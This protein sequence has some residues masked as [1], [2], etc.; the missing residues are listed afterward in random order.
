MTLHDAAVA[1]KTRGG[2]TVALLQSRPR[3]RP[4]P[5]V[6]RM[7]AVGCCSSLFLH[8]VADV[9]TFDL[10]G[11]AQ[12]GRR[13]RVVPVRHHR[14]LPRRD[15]GA[16]Q[17]WCDDQS[18]RVR[19]PAA[20]RPGV[21]LGCH[22]VGRFHDPG[23]HDQH[24][25]GARRGRAVQDRHALFELSPRHLP[26]GLLRGPR[27]AQSR[28]RHPVGD[29]AANAADV[30][31]QPGIGTARLRQ[32]GRLRVLD[33]PGR[34]R[35]RHLL[36]Q[37]QSDRHRRQEPRCLHRAR[38]VRRGAQVRPADADLRHDV[39]GLQHVRRQQ[40]VPGRS[41][42]EPRARV[43]GQLQPAVHDARHR[44]WAGLRLQRRIPDGA[45]SRSERLRRQLLH[46][47]RHR[48]ERSA[49]PQPQDLPVGGP[50]RVLVRPAA[51]ERRGRTRGR[52]RPGVFQ[53]QRSVLEDAV[54]KRH[55]RFRHA[56]PDARLIQGDARQ[57]EDR[58]G[59]RRDMDRYLARSAVQPARRRRTARKRAD[60]PVVP[61]QRRRHDLDDHPG[62]QRQGALLAQHHRGDARRRRDR[63]PAARYSRV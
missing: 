54:G 20:G 53:R 8:G 33:R 49:D 42:H 17:L 30:S 22:R 15:A 18:H 52:R 38:S 5:R 34:R 56:V 61:G 11:R 12:S 32:L 1:R 16:E 37:A 2:S 62:R 44:Q 19:E 31:E 46:R 6:I 27:R 58:S 45:V 26:Y 21:V 63:H 35:V 50:R 41:G 13:G 23:L 51:R 39:A 57:P 60:R 47:C 4:R 40:P 24:Q 10:A 14:K 29:V 3:R 36:R 55:R 28:D 25:R 7:P 59:R 48:P 43:Q 9:E